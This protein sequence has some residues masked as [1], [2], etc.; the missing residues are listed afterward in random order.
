MSDSSNSSSCSCSSSST[1]PLQTLNDICVTRKTPYRFY[2]RIHKRRG[3]DGDGGFSADLVV[4]SYT[5]SGKHVHSTKKA[6]K[7]EVAEDYLTYLSLSPSIPVNP[8]ECEH[9]LLKPDMRPRD[10]WVFKSETH[11]S[12]EL[13]MDVIALKAMMTDLLERVYQIELKL[14]HS[15]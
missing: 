2:V 5:Y 9:A 4:G 8:K 12:R 11:L 15:I 7:I 10:P 6:A 13:E 3:C 1:S 14:Q